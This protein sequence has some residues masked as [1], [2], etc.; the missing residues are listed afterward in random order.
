METVFL[1]ALCICFVAAY[2]HVINDIFD[3][4]MDTAAGKPNAMGA[5]ST[6]ARVAF[7]L[8]LLGGGFGC[9]VVLGAQPLLVGLLA[10]N[11]LLPT[12]YSAPPTRFKE[13]GISSVLSDLL[14]SHV[15]PTLFVGVAL[16]GISGGDTDLANDLIASAVAWAA[17]VGLRGILVHQAV[18][19]HN[20]RAANVSTFGGRLGRD[21]VRAFVVKVVLPL[22]G[23]TLAVLLY[24]VLP[25]S[26]ILAV[27]VVIYAAGEVSRMWR[28]VRLPHLFPEQPGRER[29]LPFLKN[30]FHEVWL[31]CALALQLALNSPVYT[32]LLIAHVIL[33]RHGI[34]DVA[35]LITKFVQE[36]FGG[37]FS[38]STNAA[39]RWKRDT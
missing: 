3:V 25:F 20:D 18:D 36:Q 14:A 27:A 23:L 39:T 34:Q 31:P 21:T 32:A 33:F 28:G 22:E 29:H 30:D 13:R 26:N 15:V 8:L 9:L 10:T 1:V 4:K 19:S 17:L 7:L 12:L 38:V 6:S 16:I 35:L 37:L 24:I 2:G 5:V 11:Y